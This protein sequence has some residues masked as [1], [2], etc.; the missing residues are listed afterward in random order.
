MCYIF[1][2]W[3]SDTDMAVCMYIWVIDLFN[4]VKHLL[5]IIVDMIYDIILVSSTYSTDLWNCPIWVSSYKYTKL[6][7]HEKHKFLKLGQ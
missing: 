7:S 5:L 2:L 1:S 6:F 4:L 3:S